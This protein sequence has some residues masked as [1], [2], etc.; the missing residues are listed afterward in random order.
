VLSKAQPDSE[1]AI[2][3]AADS[4]T[5]TSSNFESNVVGSDADFRS[6]LVADVWA[7]G[8]VGWRL[9]EGGY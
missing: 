2:A 6:V 8:S 9:D 3:D 5:S 7:N 1:D 4:S